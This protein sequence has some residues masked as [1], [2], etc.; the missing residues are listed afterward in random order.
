MKREWNRSHVTISSTGSANAYVLTY[1]TAPASYINGQR[2][3]F[4][5]NF[6]NTGSATAN[7]NGLGAKTINQHGGSG[8]A[9]LAGS[10]IQS[11]HHVTLEYDSGADV[12]VLV[13]PS[14]A[15]SGSLGTMASQNANAVAIT[16]GTV[17]GITDLAVADG[18]TGRSTLTAHGVLVG[19]GTSGVNATTAG[20]AGQVLTSNGAA[21]D[22]TFQT[23]T[24]G[25]GTTYAN[26]VLLTSGTTWSVPAGVTQVMAIL[27]A[28]GGGGGGVSANGGSAN[29]AGG[30]AGSAVTALIPV[31]GSVTYS[32][33]SAGSA[34]NSGGSSG[35]NG[36]DTVFG[37][38]TA[39]G[40]KGGGGKN[41]TGAGSTPA[42][43]LPPGILPSAN[44]A[45]TGLFIDYGTSI[46]GVG[47]GGGTGSNS[48][49]GTGGAA[50]S[51]GNGNAG[52][53][54][55]AAGGGAG[56]TNGNSATGGAGVAG[57]IVIFY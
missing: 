37:S 32:I 21:S 16:G 31:S 34:G 57:C 22:P 51:P 49:Y 4:K 52:S 46:T 33:G 20:T 3:S 30:T 28:G 7:I 55:G 40:G 38:I 19:N 6:A 1:L 10:E 17:V 25:A 26:Y 53:G 12:L 56:A 43:P 5:A 36:G 41:G 39:K 2:F 54:Y 45:A 8:L 24:A 9:V 48:L 29:G 11:G 18:G 15:T 14:P 42:F 23:P 50:G 27:Q 47:S 44:A 35:G 13:S